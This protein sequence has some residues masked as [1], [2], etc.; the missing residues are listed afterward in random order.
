MFVRIKNKGPYRYLQVV[1]NH[2]QGQRTVQH[3]IGTLGRLDAL[4]ARG[5]VD[6]LLRSLSRF[7][8]QVRLVE[9]ARQGRLQAGPARSIGPDLLC[10]RLWEQ[11]GL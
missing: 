9:D 5:Q 10:A 1:E 11:L 6:D 8:T 2:R 4:S 3:V 7:A